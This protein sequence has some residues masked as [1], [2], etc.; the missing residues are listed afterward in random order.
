MEIETT[1][2][3]SNENQQAINVDYFVYYFAQLFYNVTLLA[4]YS[5]Q[6]FTEH[7]ECLDPTHHRHHKF[8]VTDT[9]DVAFLLGFVILL[10]DFINSNILVIVY[11]FKL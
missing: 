3:S 4:L 11:R 5:V 10:Y 9:F 6:V 2:W 1:E 8:N 7:P